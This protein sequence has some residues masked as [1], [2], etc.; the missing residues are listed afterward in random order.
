M[1]KLAS[2]ALA[3][4]LAFPAYAQECE[5]PVTKLEKDD[6][7]PCEGFLFSREKELEVREKIM[8]YDELLE[9]QKLYIQQIDLHKKETE[10]AEKEAEKQEEKVKLWQDRAEDITL[11]YTEA[12]D[13]RGTRDLFFLIGGVLLTVGAGFAVG[14]ASR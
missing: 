2:L 1:K 5:V 3:G 4:L 10:L 8:E 12:Q 9:Q 14:Q 11:K 7:A 6:P 13:G